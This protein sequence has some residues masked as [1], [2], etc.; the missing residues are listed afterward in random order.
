M[1]ITAEQDPKNMA[2][3]E[4][5]QTIKAHPD[6]FIGIKSAHYR[7]FDVFNE[8]YPSWI[9]VDRAIETGEIADKLVMIDFWHRCLDRTV[10]ELFK[11]MR[12]GDIFTHFFRVIYP[13]NKKEQ[14]KDFLIK[15]R[16]KGIY[17]DLGHG[18]Y[19]FWLKKALPSTKSGFFPDVVSTDSHTGCVNGPVFDL[20]TVISKMLALGMPFE[21]LIE[22]FTVRQAQFIGRKDLGHLPVGSMADIAVLKVRTMDFWFSDCGKVKMLGDKKIECLFTLRKGEIVYDPQ[23]LSSIAIE[24]ASYEYWHW[25][26]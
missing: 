1:E 25:A 16:K 3:E 7:P 20:L 15:A 17:F 14:L 5:V 10:E 23:G 12:A 18:A 8:A 21:Q 24:D 13:F 11:R 2:P 19:S 26:H 9:S 4:T 22:S 6:V